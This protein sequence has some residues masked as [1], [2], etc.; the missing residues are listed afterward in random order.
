MNVRVEKI[1]IEK[2][3]EGIEKI[4]MNGIEKRDMKCDKII[5]DLYEGDEN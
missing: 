1:I 3:I 5:I 2:M 4:N